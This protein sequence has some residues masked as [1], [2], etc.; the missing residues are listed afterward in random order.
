MEDTVKIEKGVP[1][2]GL[3]VGRS[4]KYPWRE[5]EVGDSFVI[6]KSAY[7]QAQLASKRTGFKFSVRKVDGAY[8]V[9]RIA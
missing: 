8:R 1:M 6:Q 5:M 2:P 4:R 9:W 3:G 7:A